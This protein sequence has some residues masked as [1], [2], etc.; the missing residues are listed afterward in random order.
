MRQGMAPTEYLLRRTMM[1]PR[2]L[3]RLLQLVRDDMIDRRDDPFA[4]QEV[5]EAR[6]ECSAIY[7]AEPNYSDW[8]KGEIIDEWRAQKPEITKYLDAIQNLGSTVLSKDSFNGALTNIGLKLGEPQVA[9]V[10]R[11]LFANSLSG[12]KFGRSQQWRF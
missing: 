11:F 12:L 6:L 1:R 10:L 9:E 4:A 7:N 3:I 8:L 5:N 2:D